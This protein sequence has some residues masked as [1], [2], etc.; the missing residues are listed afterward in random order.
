MS[1]DRDPDGYDRLERRTSSFGERQ[2]GNL[3]DRPGR[4]L[5]K[6][7]VSL[8]ALVLA[9]GLLGQAIGFISLWG[10]EAQRITGPDNVRDQHTA[11]IGTWED[12]ISA[13]ETACQVGDG[14]ERTSVDP[15]LV[16]DTAIAYSSTF[17]NIRAEYNRRQQNLFEARLVGPKGYPRTVPF[18]RAAMPGPQNDWCKVARKL[19]RI[20]P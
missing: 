13:A 8:L 20:H 6:W 14:G 5:F 12:M 11:I 17:R 3:A 4:T 18:Y 16:E 19:V 15:T 7:F 10:G 2:A 1:R 9:I